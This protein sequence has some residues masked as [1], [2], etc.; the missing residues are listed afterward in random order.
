MRPAGT[1]A[2]TAARASAPPGVA[3]LSAGAASGENAPIEMR[4]A[5]SRAARTALGRRSGS[6]SP[7]QCTRSSPRRGSSPPA[8]RAATIEPAEVPISCFARRKSSPVACW[9][10]PR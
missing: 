2:S 1:R 4:L 6:A 9:A 5:R 7:S 10:P 3:A 8:S